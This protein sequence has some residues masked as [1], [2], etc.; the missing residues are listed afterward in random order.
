MQISDE[1]EK[2]RQREKAKRYYKENKE[3]VNKR[4]SEWH[5]NNPESQNKCT[6]KNREMLNDN[7]IKEQLQS[8]HHL[9]KE[10]I[11][12]EMIEM[13]EMKRIEINFKRIIKQL[14]NGNES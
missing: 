9:N 2:L 6:R 11:T 7:Y 12:T 8:T 5:K 3:K 10:D 1:K 14:K 4:T 13:I